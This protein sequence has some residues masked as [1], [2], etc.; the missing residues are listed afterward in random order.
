MRRQDVATLIRAAREDIG[1]TPADL[2]R[3]AG[4]LQPDLEAYEAGYRIPREETLRKILSAAR[5]RPSV[6][7]ELV[8]DEIN[9]AAQA[10]R[11]SNVRVFGSVL[12]GRDT[13]NSDIDLIVTAS[14]GVSL[15][16]L[17]AFALEVEDL[18][19]FRADVATDE[20]LEKPAFAH[21]RD[22]AVPL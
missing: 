3:A 22:D 7:L 16:D 1:M 10:H 20:L 2:A 14:A 12:Q 6:P 21:V 18:T 13:E 17:S 15:F 4:I 8:A 9:A 19:G 5:L 11:L